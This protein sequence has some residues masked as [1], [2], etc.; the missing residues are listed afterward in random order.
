M[1]RRLAN[2]FI[3]Y[4]GFSILCGLGILILCTIRIP[5]Q[6]NVSMF[7]NFDKFVHFMMYF[8]LSIAIILETLKLKSQA[9]KSIFRTF[10]AA[11]II[12]AVFG[13]LIEFI[14]GTFT[15]YRSAS[16]MD[17]VADMAGSVLACLFIGLIHLAFRSRGR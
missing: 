3:Q 9:G 1:T 6:D 10:I 14:Q 11:L 2:K 15:S 12:S 17:W 16:F 7:P 5:P 8:S 13:A 4:H